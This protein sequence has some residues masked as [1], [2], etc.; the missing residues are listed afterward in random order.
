M[1]RE[2]AARS[3]EKVRA[4]DDQSLLPGTGLHPFAIRKIADRREAVSVGP[5]KVQFRE[6]GV[7]REWESDD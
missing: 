5:R 2:T 7:V 3:G 6:E 4:G 1:T